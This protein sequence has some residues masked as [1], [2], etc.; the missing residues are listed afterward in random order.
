M[1]DGEVGREGVSFFFNGFFHLWTCLAL[2]AGAVLC[3][4][5]FE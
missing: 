2:L 5:G 3:H 4:G 1:G